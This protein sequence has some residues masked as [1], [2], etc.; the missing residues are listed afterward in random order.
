MSLWQNSA[1]K[2]L[3]PVKHQNKNNDSSLRENTKKREREE[4]EEHSREDETS[5]RL[6]QCECEHAH[7][8][9]IMIQSFFVCIGVHV[10][11]QSKQ[12]SEAPGWVK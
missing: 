6:Q 2:I 4:K 5:L 8:P 10:T 11:C 3:S 9:V 1:L 7:V 12:F